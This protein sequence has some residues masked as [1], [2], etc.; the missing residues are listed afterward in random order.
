[1]ARKM[2]HELDTFKEETHAEII[3][4]EDSLGMVENQNAWNKD[5]SCGECKRA[6]LLLNLGG[7][8]FTKRTSILLEQNLVLK[9]KSKNRG[10]QILRKG[11]IMGCRRLRAWSLDSVMLPD[12][13][14]ILLR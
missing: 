7:C 14:P 4:S 10:F 1:M 13:M 9:I 2:Q 11:T 8:P 6:G 12:G 3:E 5:T